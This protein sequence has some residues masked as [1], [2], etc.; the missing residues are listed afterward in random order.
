MEAIEELKERL[1][2]LQRT[3][4]HEI[5][6]DLADKLLLEYIG[7]REVTILHRKVAWWCA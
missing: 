5:Q 6:H 7:D 3:D 4:D 1:I 2:E